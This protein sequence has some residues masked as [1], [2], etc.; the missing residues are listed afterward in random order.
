MLGSD[1]E[2]VEEKILKEG[3]QKKREESIWLCLEVRIKLIMFQ[4]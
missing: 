2:D 4:R 1:N 3:S